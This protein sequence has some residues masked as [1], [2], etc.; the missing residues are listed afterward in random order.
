MCI[1]NSE[2]PDNRHYPSTHSPYLSVH[3]RVYSNRLSHITVR[4]TSMSAHSSPRKHICSL[5]HSYVCTSALEHLCTQSPTLAHARTHSHVRLCRRRLTHQSGRH[6]VASS[7]IRLSVHS[8][9]RS[10]IHAQCT[11]LL[12]AFNCFFVK[13][14]TAASFCPIV[15]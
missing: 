14:S 15:H 8:R 7:R 12:H 6:W 13:R 2:V 11:P 1:H 3:S 10:L 4:V 9:I 5:I